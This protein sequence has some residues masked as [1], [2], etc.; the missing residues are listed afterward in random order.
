MAL[1]KC[2][3]ST[4]ANGGEGRQ[5][6]DSGIV[7]VFPVAISEGFLQGEKHCTVSSKKG[8]ERKRKERKKGGYCFFVNE[9]PEEPRTF[10]RFLRTTVLRG[11]TYMNEQ[12]EREQR[13]GLL[14]WKWEHRSC[15]V[16]ASERHDF[17][18]RDV[19][20]KLCQARHW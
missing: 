13:G 18:I 15:V 5:G 20:T 7:Q 11:L 9:G 1:C 14:V 17:Q 12:Q 19:I 8:K 16:D 2:S 6:G 10:I 3:C 4:S